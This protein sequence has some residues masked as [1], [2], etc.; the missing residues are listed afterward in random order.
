MACKEHEHL[1][2]AVAQLAVGLGAARGPGLL[3]LHRLPGIDLQGL[4]KRPCYAIL[5]H[6]Q[7]ISMRFMMFHVSFLAIL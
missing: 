7:G 3:T 1:R 5:C 6:F 2:E 4:R